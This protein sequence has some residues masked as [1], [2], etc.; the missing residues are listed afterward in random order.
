MVE[1]R[2][3]RLPRAFVVHAVEQLKRVP[4][5]RGEAFDHRISQRLA[6]RQ[7]QARHLVG[8][9]LVG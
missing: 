6:H 4:A 1:Q 9:R 7:G 5:H 2:M 3:H 8:R